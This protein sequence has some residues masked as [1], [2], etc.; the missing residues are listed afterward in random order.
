[1]VASLLKPSEEYSRALAFILS[2][3]DKFQIVTS[4]QVRDEYAEVHSRRFITL[5][6][7]SK[8]ANGLL[9]IIDDVSVEVV[10]KSL[11]HLPF[12]DVDN[13]PFV[14]LA[15]YTNSIVVTNNVANFP[16]ADLKVLRAG[17]FLKL[18]GS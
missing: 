13:K 15:V 10:P 1:M 4:S 16:F 2:N 3:L 17:E 9:E 5:R 12:P 11:A 8:V 7:L 18:F 6:G 14:E